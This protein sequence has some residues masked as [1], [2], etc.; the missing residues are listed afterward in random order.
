MTSLQEGLNGLRRRRLIDISSIK[1]HFSSHSYVSSDV[2]LVRL[3]F[4]FVPPSDFNFALVTF[5]ILSIKIIKLLD[6]SQ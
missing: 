6:K 2:Y 1:I 5:F 4:F 3:T